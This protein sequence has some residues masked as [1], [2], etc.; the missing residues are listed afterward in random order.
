MTII[1]IL[2]CNYECS[3]I[4]C[5]KSG[6]ALQNKNRTRID[7]QAKTEA[8]SEQFF[9]RYVRTRAAMLTQVFVLTRRRGDK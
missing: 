5:R 2:A 8:I 6:V 3:I 4:I 1:P 7:M 9:L